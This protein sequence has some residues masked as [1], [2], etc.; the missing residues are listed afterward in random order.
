MGDDASNHAHPA[1]SRGGLQRGIYVLPSLFT[2]G[3]LVCGYIAILSTL[4][5]IAFVDNTYSMTSFDAAARAI[6]WALLFVG[7]DARIARITN[8]SS[9]FCRDFDCH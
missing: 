9:N 8:G 7:L 3:T 6:G 2:V 5:A 1:R 4:Q